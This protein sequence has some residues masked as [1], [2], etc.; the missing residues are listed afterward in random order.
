MIFKFGGKTFYKIIK[1]YLQNLFTRVNSNSMLH[2]FP[3]FLH[4][5]ESEGLNRRSSKMQKKKFFANPYTILFLLD[6]MWKWIF[7]IWKEPNK[8]FLSE[9]ILHIIDKCSRKINIVETK[10]FI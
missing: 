6:P 7:S 8:L 10:S 5:L 2:S 9:A 3:H 4:Y 1:V